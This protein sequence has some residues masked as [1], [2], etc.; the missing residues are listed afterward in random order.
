M[1]R[2]LSKLLETKKLNMTIIIRLLSKFVLILVFLMFSPSSK[3]H[4][5]IYGSSVISNFL[6]PGLT[7]NKENETYTLNFN[8]LR[9][10]RAGA[11]L[12][13]SINRSF[14]LIDKY[15]GIYD[16]KSLRGKLS[17]NTPKITNNSNIDGR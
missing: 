2:R 12:Q 17:I 15:I 16:R 5:I 8:I 9:L 7:G 13:V 3:F 4:V 6:I 1:Y 11:R 10:N 14:T